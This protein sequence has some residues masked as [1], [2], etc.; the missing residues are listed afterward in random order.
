MAKFS[1]P[2]A[3]RRRRWSQALDLQ[4]LFD[5]QTMQPRTVMVA[6]RLNAWLR[7]S[8]VQGMCPAQLGRTFASAAS[9]RQLKV[10][11]IG[12]G[13]ISNLHN[14]G[15]SALD[16]AVVHGLWSRT[17]EQVPEPA[18]KA[19]EYG[20]KLYFSAEELVAEGLQR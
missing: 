10:G 8:C 15:F 2:A 19:A 18:T 20:C 4:L 6:T 5:R 13:D 9:P 1:G 7:P 14:E 11:F 12:A 17:D 3:V 16:G